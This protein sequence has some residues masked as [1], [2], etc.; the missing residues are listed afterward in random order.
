METAQK[1]VRKPS[2]RALALAKEIFSAAKYEGDGD[3]LDVTSAA[4]LIDQVPKKYDSEADTLKHIKRVNEL[5]LDAAMEL[6]RRAQVHDDSKLEE[7][8]K[9]EFD[10]LTPM[11]AGTTYGSDEYKALLGEL[12]VA[13][14]H[15]YSENS[16]HPEHHEHGVNGMTL[17]DVVE[18]FFDW[19]AA[20]ERHDDGN[21]YKSIEYNK[22]RFGLS[23]QLAVIFVNTAEELGYKREE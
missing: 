6:M 17:F 3:S 8:E 15:H 23:D 18:M 5:L 14:D 2:P 11:L 21:I 10:R 4:H 19:K 1:K 22:G 12:R 20:T 16:H 9:S 13:L 7:P